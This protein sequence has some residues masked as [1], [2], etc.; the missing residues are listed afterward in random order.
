ML[1][2]IKLQNEKETHTV[3]MFGMLLRFGNGEKPLFKSDIL[4]IIENFF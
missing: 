1:K 2:E 3:L 4:L